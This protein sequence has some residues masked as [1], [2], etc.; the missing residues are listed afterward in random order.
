MGV[1]PILYPDIGRY[2]LQHSRCYF[3]KKKLSERLINFFTVHLPFCLSYHILS[4]KMMYIF[5]VLSSI[6]RNLIMYFLQ[7]LGNLSHPRKTSAMN[8]SSRGWIFQVWVICCYNFNLRNGFWFVKSNTWL[9]LVMKNTV[10]IW[11]IVITV[12]YN[13]KHGDKISL[14]R[15]VK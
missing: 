10:H 7:H 2:I 9:Y 14:L 5:M 15:G 6:I 4:N 1:D 3:H 13:H 11:Y 8:Q 12:L